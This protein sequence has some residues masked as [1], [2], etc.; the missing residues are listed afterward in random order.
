M[1]IQRIPSSELEVG[2]Q[3]TL[4]NNE[5]E[6]SI[7]L[8]VRQ[9]GQGPEIL[10][11]LQDP[12]YSN[13]LIPHITSLETTGAE[14]FQYLQSAFP[15]FPGTLTSLCSLDI[16]ESTP[17]GSDPLLSDFPRTLESLHLDYIPLYPSLQK[18]DSL[19][20]F[21][22]RDLNFAHPLDTLLTFL[23]RNSSLRQVDLC[24]QFGNYAHRRSK[25]QGAI[26]LQHLRHL[27]V[28]GD[29]MPRKD[30]KRLIRHI[31]PT[32]GVD[33]KTRFAETRTPTRSIDSKSPTYMYVNYRTGTIQLAAQSRIVFFISLSYSEISSLFVRVP[34]PSLP[35]MY[36][37]ATLPSFG[38]V[39]GLGVVMP[40]SLKR[41]PTSLELQWFASLQTLIIK[42]G[43]H[44]STATLP[45]VPRT[46]DFTLEIMHSTRSNDQMNQLP[47]DP[48]SDKCYI[49][50]GTSERIGVAIRVVRN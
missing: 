20:G 4:M 21:H 16:L 33:L 10:K 34:Q 24:I 38:Y 8:T 1:S 26:Q 46:S 29:G 50:V 11:T 27:S 17:N 31:S 22:L 45:K 42:K 28:G 37:G 32:Q 19:T 7:R 43:K 36:K 41:E 12:S 9:P 14:S 15:G 18:I 39:E 13:A 44:T 35:F 23:E 3:P 2:S 47:L 25:R 49:R 48:N 30:I 40:R 5:S 6:R